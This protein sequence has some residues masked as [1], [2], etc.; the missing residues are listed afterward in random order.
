ME[1]DWTTS[2]SLINF[3]PVTDLYEFLQGQSFVIVRG[4][5]IGPTEKGAETIESWLEFQEPLAKM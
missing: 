1:D 5:Y 3:P 2:I 4:C